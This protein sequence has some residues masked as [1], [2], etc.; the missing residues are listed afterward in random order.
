MYKKNKHIHFIGIGGIGMSGIAQVLKQ[1]GYLVSGC[2]VSEN[3]KILEHLKSIGCPIHHQH[4]EKHISDVDVLVYS[5]AVNH[6]NPEVQAA[7][8]KG[9]PV[10]PRAIMLAELMRMKYGIAVAGAHGKTTTTSILSHILI[11][12]KLDPTVIIGGVLK[13]ISTHAQLGTGSLLIAEADESDR[14]LLHLSPSLAIVTNID[15]EHLDTY[16]NINDVKET[17][18][19]FLARLPFYGKAFVCIDDANIRS[20]LPLPSIKVVKYG[21][22]DDA[23]IMG[24][25]IELNKTNSKFNVYKR[26]K[27][28]NR[29]TLLG[30]ITLNMPGEHNV[31][32]ALASIAMSL[33][34]DIPFKSIQKSLKIFKGIERRFEFKGNFNGTDIFDDYGHH[35]TEIQKTLLVAQK[36]V[37]NKLVAIFQPHRFSRTQKLW[38]DFVDTFTYSSIDTLYITDIYPASE[39]PIDGITSKKLAAHIQ[40]KNPKITVHYFSKYDEITQ[41]VEKKIGKGDLLITI[42][43]GKVNLIGETLVEQK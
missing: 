16:K 6:S 18:K 11:E 43:A 20:I 28:S 21:L 38:D 19:T 40:K 24:N 35:P 32:N 30:T 41:H 29:H 2:D 3:T 39:A 31:L 5:S 13:N 4:S 36:R 25:I 22:N 1:Q 15:A 34:F 17:F 12:A 10:I 8:E 42:G 23:D 9:I 33:E 26:V 37:Q 7:L 27:T 14:S